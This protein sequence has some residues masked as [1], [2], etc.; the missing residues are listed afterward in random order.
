MKT[1]E[2]WL[3]ELPDGYRQL[4]LNNCRKSSLQ[5]KVESI[6]MSIDRG[7]VWEDS[8]EGWDFWDKVYSH[9]VDSTKTTLPKLPEL[10]IKNNWQDISTAPKNGTRILIWDGED[11]YIADWREWND[12]NGWFIDYFGEEK[13]NPT[14]WQSLPKPPIV[15]L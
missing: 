6:E 2:E 5:K 3:E 13:I 7:F 10:P 8:F 9:Y 11:Y 15:Y 4:A 12:K 1:I 14:H